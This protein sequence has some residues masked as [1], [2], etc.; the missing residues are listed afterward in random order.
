MDAGSG[1]GYLLDGLDEAVAVP[2][3]SEPLPVSALTRPAV[4][5]GVDTIAQPRR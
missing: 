4:W 1:F 3:A 2:V 5:D